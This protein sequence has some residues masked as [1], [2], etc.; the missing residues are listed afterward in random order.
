MAMDQ[1]CWRHL[2][3]MLEWGSTRERGMRRI[4]GVVMMERGEEND[5]EKEAIKNAGTIVLSK[6]LKDC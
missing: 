1:D 4:G 2:D 3:W 5:V 6:L